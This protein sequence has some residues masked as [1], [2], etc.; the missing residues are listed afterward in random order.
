VEVARRFIPGLDERWQRYGLGRWERWHRWQ[1][2]G[3][4]A[5]FRAATP[6]RR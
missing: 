6:L 4:K 1:S 3:R 5:E 2:D